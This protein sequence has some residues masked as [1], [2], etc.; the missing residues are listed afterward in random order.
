MNSKANCI[1]I[2]GGPSVGKTTLISLMRA[3]GQQVLQ[4][5]AIEII[6]EGVYHPA[7]NR[8]EF[9]E[10]ILRRQIYLEANRLL[11]RVCFCDRGLLDGAAYYLN[12]GLPVPDIF[13]QLDISHYRACFVLMPLETFEQETLRPNFEDLEFTRRITPLIDQCYRQ[14]GVPV[15]TV[16]NIG[17]EKR[18]EFIEN[19]CM[20]LNLFETR[21]R[22]QRPRHLAM[23]TQL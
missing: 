2:S 20:K 9:Q 10:E 8:Q 23:Q 16:P 12:D 17:I 14:R 5:V 7:K 11:D 13:E 22:V 18:L 4:E 19:E 1:V 21:H 15:I 3:R 6:K